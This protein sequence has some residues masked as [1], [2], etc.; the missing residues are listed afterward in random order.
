MSTPEFDYIYLAECGRK[1]AR[2][3]YGVVISKRNWDDALQHC[4]LTMLRKRKRKPGISES[5]LVCV[6]ANGLR[7][8]ARSL[9]RRPTVQFFEPLDGKPG[10]DFDYS[11]DGEPVSESSQVEDVD[12]NFLS[13]VLDLDDLPSRGWT[14]DLAELMHR[15]DMQQ[16]QILRLRIEQRQTW[17]EIA[18]ALG[19]AE[20]ELDYIK[21]TIRDKYDELRN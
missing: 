3:K 2:R 1:Y 14:A 10:Y 18:S 21:D 6:A 16:R 15:C 17:D 9:R 7:N 20:S 13:D 4:V 11:P 8:F 19:L 12:R 5:E